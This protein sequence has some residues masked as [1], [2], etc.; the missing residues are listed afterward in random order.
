MS[1]I[2]DAFINQKAFIGFVTGG[3]PDLKTSEEIILKMIAGGCDLIEIGIPFSDPVAEGPVIQEANLRALAAGATVDSIF[4]LAASVRAKT[5][6]PLVLLTY[7]N[8]VYH[9]GYQDF[10]AGCRRSGI[11]GIII[12]DL[13]YEEKGELQPYAAL[14]GIDLITLIAPTSGQRIARLAEDAAGFIYIVSSMGVTGTRTQLSDSLTDTMA[15][16]KA[17]TDVPVAV[18]FGIHTPEQAAG[19]AKSADG[20]IVGS[21]IVRLAAQ[22]GQEAP[23]YIYHYIKQM[24]AAIS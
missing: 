3:D 9:Y 24:K 20:I 21:A 5:A 17:V 23:D 4:T 8:P 2:K 11:D 10:F 13:P 18:G 19:I 7:L 22:Y 15:A 16:V 1:R 14:Q 12:P 6:V